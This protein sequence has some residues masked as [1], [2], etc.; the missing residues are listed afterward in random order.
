MVRSCDVGSLPFTGDMHRFLEGA[1]RYS[2]LSKDSESLYFEEKTVQ[3]FMD[4]IEAGVAVPNYPQFRDMSEMFLSMINGVEKA[5]G[6]YVETGPLSLKNEK[7]MLP[8]VEAIRKH[9]QAFYEK[10]NGSFKLRICITGP[11]TLASQFLYRDTRIYSRLGQILA[12]IVEN[13]LFSNKHGSVS[14]VTLDEPIFGLVDDPSMDRGSEARENLRNAWESILEK[15]SSKN[16]QT[17]LHIHSTR[18]ELFWEIKS[19]NVV[20]TPVNDPIYESKRTKKLLESTDKFLNASIT[21]ADF[22]Q[23]IRNYLVANS[24]QRMSEIEL[25]ERVGEAWKNIREGKADPQNFLE[26][27]DLMRARLAK[28]IDSFGVN[29]IS[30]GVPECGLRGFPTYE[31]AIECLRRVAKAT[32]TF[33][34]ES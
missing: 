20:E 12:K 21:I 6:G 26:S 5:K 7:A 1:S 13:N 4:K 28:L 10:I 8:E 2:S 25:N 23:L 16:V 11:Y 30:Y 22:D 18:D 9:A 32:E 15:A 17:C 31:C 14:L 19:I 34:T 29:R 33:T 3:S 27:I 24:K